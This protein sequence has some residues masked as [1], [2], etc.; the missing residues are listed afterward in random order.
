MGLD[1]SVTKQGKPLDLSDAKI[2]VHYIEGTGQQKNEVLI[3]EREK[4]D[5]LGELKVPASTNGN[6]SFSISKEKYS[7]DPT[8]GWIMVDCDCVN[9]EACKPV[10]TIEMKQDSCTDYPNNFF[11]NVSSCNDHISVE[12]ATVTLTLKEYGNTGISNRIG[13][14]QITPENGIV[15]F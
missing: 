4:T 12:G 6:Y 11:V 10:V 3:T 15:S 7:K 5:K 9:E 8:V 14:P 2:T 13:E 1:I